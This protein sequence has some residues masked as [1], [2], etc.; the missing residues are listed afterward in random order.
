MNTQRV[1]VTA[2]AA[3]IGR[4]I[5][6]AFCAKGAKVHICDINQEA[7]QTLA[8]EI[9]GLSYSLIDVGDEV[10]VTQF[11]QDG[12]K[13]LGGIDVLINNA[14]IGGPAG[15]LESLDSKDWQQTIQINLNS[16]FLCCKQALPFMKKQGS[17]SIINLSSSAGVMGYPFRTPY[18]AAKW[19]VIGLTKSLAIESGGKGIRVNAICPGSVSGER[20]DRVIANESSARGISEQEVRDSYVANSSLKTFIDPEDIA[21]MALFLSSDMGKRISGQVISVDGDTHTLA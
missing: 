21:A 18:A 1:F 2:G 10:Q 13:Q 3:G 5:T 16:T 15:P 6:R 14:G 20:M 19:A 7:L 17:G 11:F 8:T 9:P 12:L 4:A